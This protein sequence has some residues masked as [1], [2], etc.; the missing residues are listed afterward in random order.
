MP[1]RK[2]GHGHEHGYEYE[3]D[4]DHGRGRGRHRGRAPSPEQAASWAGIGRTW[5]KV[6][7]NMGKVALETSMETL[8]TA[9]DTLDKLSRAADRDPGTLCY[10]E[11]DECGER[12][13]GRRRQDYVDSREGNY[14]YEQKAAAEP[15]RPSERAEDRETA[16]SVPPSEDKTE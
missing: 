4:R 9:A 15:R 2:H 6:G 11:Y 16:S 7:L 14:R 1:R 12:P 13:A 8:R 3:Y 5:A 10:D